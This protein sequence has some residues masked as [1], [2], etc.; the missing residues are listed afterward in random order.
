MSS[1]FL[2]LSVSGTFMPFW[3][4]AFV[5]AVQKS[6][7]VTS[8]DHSGKKV[9]TTQTTQTIL[10][11]LWKTS[12]VITNL[13]A[14]ADDDD[15]EIQLA[16]SDQIVVGGFGTLAALITFFSEYTLKT[17]GC[18]LPAGPLGLYGLAEGL[19][20]LAVTGIAAFSLVTKVKTVS[21]NI[22]SSGGKNPFKWIS[23]K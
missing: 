18:G 21:S 11:Q 7:L 12:T 19:S 22:S 5:P 4:V 17:T 3:C 14:S 9:T 2:L 13:A 16:E 23:I 20:Y 15:N 10:V 6:F 1:L 8:I